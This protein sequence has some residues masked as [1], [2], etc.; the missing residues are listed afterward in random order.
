MVVVLGF[1][2]DFINLK[3]FPFHFLLCLYERPKKQIVLGMAQIGVA[4]SFL[5]IYFWECLSKILTSSIF[6]YYDLKI[7]KKPR[8]NIFWEKSLYIFLSITVGKHT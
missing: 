5:D 6:M 4:I 2:G 7:S 8:L 3:S 1:H